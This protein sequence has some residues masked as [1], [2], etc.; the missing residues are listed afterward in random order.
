MVVK[1][2]LSFTDSEIPQK[3]TSERIA[4]NARATATVGSVTNSVR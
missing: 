1:T 3:L 2:K 4:R